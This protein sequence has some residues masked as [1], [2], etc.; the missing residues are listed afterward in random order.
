MGY[1]THVIPQKELI[2]LRKTVEFSAIDISTNSGIGTTNERL[3][4]SG[5]KNQSIKPEN[6]LDGYRIGAKNYDTLK[7]LISGL[8][9][10][11]P[12]SLVLE[13]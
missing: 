5:Q 13:L 3:Y 1:I 7:V 6:V 12:L 2:L 9:L 4:L 8:S 10:E 11:S